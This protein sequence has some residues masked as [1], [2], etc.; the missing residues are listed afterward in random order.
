MARA[1]VPEAKLVETEAGM[2]P[3]G[4]GWFVVNVADAMSMG[5]DES[6]KPAATY[7]AE[8]G[9]EAFLVLQ[10][11]SVLII[12]D[13]ARRMRK[14]DFVHYPPHTAHVIVGARE[15]PAPC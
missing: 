10:G 14:W 5:I 9:Q 8:A 2:K 13:Q 6:H 11:E 1:P 4:D 3:E 7:H 15:A 12:E